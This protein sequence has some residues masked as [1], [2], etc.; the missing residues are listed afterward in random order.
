[1][2][3]PLLSRLNV[4]G[5]TALGCIAYLLWRGWNGL[6]TSGKENCNPIPLGSLI[7]LTLFTLYRIAIFVCVSIAP[8]DAP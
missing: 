6:R 5:K 3:L 4:D 2:R 7:R 1:M 8:Q